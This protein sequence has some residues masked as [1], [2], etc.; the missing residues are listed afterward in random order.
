MDHGLRHQEL[1]TACNS[2][3]MRVNRWQT[4]IFKDF[5]HIDGPAVLDRSL[6]HH[7]KRVIVS[8]QVKDMFPVINTN[9]FQ[10]ASF[11]FHQ[12]QLLFCADTRTEDCNTHAIPPSLPRLLVLAQGWVV[13]G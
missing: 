12:Q 10:A 5:E 9:I 8:M 1:V 7:V 4:G 3:P 11:Q 13:P 6:Q 2:D